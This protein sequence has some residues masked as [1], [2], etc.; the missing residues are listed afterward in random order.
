MTVIVNG[1]LPSAPPP[2]PPPQL[3]GRFEAFYHSHFGVLCIKLSLLCLLAGKLPPGPAGKR[4]FW[5]VFAGS[6]EQI[7]ISQQVEKL[8]QKDKFLVYFMAMIYFDEF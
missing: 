7:K 6:A 8:L 5:S 3:N 1:P 4:N 2:P